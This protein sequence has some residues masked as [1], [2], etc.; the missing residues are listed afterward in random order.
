MNNYNQNDDEKEI[1]KILAFSSLINGGVFGGYMNT[2]DIP[3]EYD[4]EEDDDNGEDRSE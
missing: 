1:S 2:I 3:D 4:E